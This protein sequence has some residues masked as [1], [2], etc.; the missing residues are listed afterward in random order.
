[1]FE[2]KVQGVLTYNLISTIKTNGSTDLTYYDLRALVSAKIRKQEQTLVLGGEGDRL[3]L[4]PKRRELMYMVSIT[5]FEPG[6]GTVHLDAGLAH[7]ICKGVTV[8]VWPSSCSHFRDSERRALLEISKVEEITSTAKIVEWYTDSET[9]KKLERGFLGQLRSLPQQPVYLDSS[10]PPCDMA[11]LRNELRKHK[12]A[13]SENPKKS[14]F[15][16][17][18]RNGSYFITGGCKPLLNAV[19]PLPVN[20][21]NATEK[22]IRRLA[23]LTRY[24]DILGLQPNEPEL[25]VASG[26]EKEPLKIPRAATW[27]SAREL[28]TN[29]IYTTSYEISENK[30]IVLR[31]TNESECRKYV[32]IIALDSEWGVEQIFPTAPGVH[33][34]PLEATESIR[35]PL[36]IILPSDARPG[37]TTDTLKVIVTTE[38]ANFRWL[39]IPSLADLENCATTTR[40]RGT[41]TKPSGPLKE[42]YEV[43]TDRKLRAI[44]YLPITSKWNSKNLNVKIPLDNPTSPYIDET[45][46]GDDTTGEKSTGTFSTPSS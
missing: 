26:I 1:M 10:I 27:Y 31:L 23:H 29:P 24:Y 44:K 42:L 18:I 11:T 38:P 33:N 35:L 28:P 8:D 5:E 17:C 30:K 39:G 15:R 9:E 12:A 34:K 21:D 4:S 20:T 14:T 43:M 36:D 3:F 25:W 46:E 40:Q 7:G 2:G 32:T 41:A 19:P 16:V 45:D 13:L 22:L 6:T 37:Q